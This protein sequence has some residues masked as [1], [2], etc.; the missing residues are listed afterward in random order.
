MGHLGP[1]KLC[2]WVFIFIIRESDWLSVNSND[3]SSRNRKLVTLSKTDMT[4]A[5]KPS[6]VLLPR[7]SLQSRMK[8]SKQHFLLWIQNWD[9]GR[10][11][12][13][14]RER[15]IA[16]GITKVNPFVLF[17]RGKIVEDTTTDKIGVIFQVRNFGL[18]WYLSHAE[19]SLA[20][21]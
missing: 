7:W 19:K 20:L 14:M 4:W 8:L 11:F 16:A 15:E 1:E 9:S 21:T 6:A 3:S 5:A 12:L 17:R 18:K 10:W 2:I 13:R